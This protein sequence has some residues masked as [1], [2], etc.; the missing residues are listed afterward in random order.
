M[1]KIIRPMLAAP[2]DLSRLCY[3]LT[4]SPKLDGVRFLVIDGKVVSRN[5]KPIP[6]Y[7]VQ[8]QFGHPRFNGLDGELIVGSPTAPNV[9][10]RTMRGV[11][12]VDGEPPVIAHVF[13]IFTVEADYS[14]RM[15]VYR[16]LIAK[17]PAMRFVPQ[18]VVQS[19]EELLQREQ[20]FLLAGYE[21]AMLRSFSAPYK[22]GRSTTKEGYLLKLKRFTDGEAEIIGF[23]E[24]RG[25]TN[26]ATTD[27]L[28]YTV[29]SSHQAGRVALGV[30]GSLEV[31]D[32]ETGVTF[33]VGS[34]FTA[35]DRSILWASREALVGRIIKYKF[36]PVGVKD[37]PRFPIF[38]GFR[39]VA[40]LSPVE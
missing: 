38:V 28:G 25:N 22:F 23:T 3:P 20:D 31:R 10:N 1:N 35:L 34:G 40:D 17:R 2:A 14:F 13:D 33:S 15:P 32:L 27:N 39:P 7:H 24:L 5:L 8:R 4:I 12:R 6:N 9:Y 16:R 21:G 11:M 36:Q 37:K 26:E 18:Y 29:R 30:L 19:E